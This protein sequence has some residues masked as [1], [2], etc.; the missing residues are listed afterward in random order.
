MRISIREIIGHTI[1]DIK[2]GAFGMQELWL[3]N[4]MVVQVWAD[5]EGNQPGWLE[6]TEDVT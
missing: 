1:E 3:D 2:E 5:A 4:G 6:I